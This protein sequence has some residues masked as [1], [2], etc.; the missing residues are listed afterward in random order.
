MVCSPNDR[1][2][3]SFMTVTPFFVFYLNK[4]INAYHWF[5]IYLPKPRHKLCLLLL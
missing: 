1:Q 4:I 3:D 5:E 2:L